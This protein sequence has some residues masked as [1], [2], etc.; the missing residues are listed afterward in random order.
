MDQLELVASASQIR[1]P[2]VRVLNHCGVH[3]HITYYIYIYEYT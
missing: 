2:A 3:K 1:V